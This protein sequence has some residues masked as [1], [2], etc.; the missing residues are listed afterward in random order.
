MGPLWTLYSAHMLNR[1]YVAGM[2]NP[3]AR[4]G[5]GRY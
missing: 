1:S 5:P 2:H 3:Q 4:S